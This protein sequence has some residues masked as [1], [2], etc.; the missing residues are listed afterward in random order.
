[1]ASHFRLLDLPAELRLLVYKNIST[2][3]HRIS[4]TY[5]DRN[6]EEEHEAADFTI[7]LTYETLSTTILATCRQIQIEAKAV[8]DAR[9]QVLE[10]DP[11]RVSLRQGNYTHI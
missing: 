10:Q 11:P 9:L 3:T 5:I 4:H 2:T 8:F 7:I 6:P 1:M